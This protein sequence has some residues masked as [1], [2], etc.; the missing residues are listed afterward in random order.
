[1]NHAAVVAR[2]ESRL[3]Q[4]CCLGLPGPTVAPML[5]RELNEVVPFETCFHMWIGT[6]GPIDAYF[7]T[8]E[9]G[10]CFALY[11]DSFFGTR[12][13]EVW[14]TT[15]EAARTEV[16]P[17]HV[18]EV[19]RLSKTAY[20]RHPIYNEIVRPCGADVFVRLMVRDGDAP[21]GS[22]QVARRAHDRD[23][24]ADDLGVLR[25]LEPFI[26]HALRSRKALATVESCDA[27]RAIVVVGADGGIRWR[28]SQA[29]RLLSLAHG[30]AAASA[31]LPAGLLDAVRAL[32]AVADARPDAHAPNWRCD[33]AWG[34]FVAR[35]YWLEPS[36]PADSLIGIEIER[37]V[38]LPLRLYEALRDVALP[39][40][41]AEVGLLLAL[42]RTHEQIAGDLHVSRN[43]VV[44]HRR[45]IYNRLGVD[46]CRRSAR[47]I[48]GIAPALTGQAHRSRL[49]RGLRP[50]SS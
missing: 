36:Q 29:D 35:A 8:P 44:Y 14:S 39:E 38:P 6:D 12:E 4:L 31:T 2:A 32:V 1:M 33:N 47:P 37:R 40:R 45:Q 21:V 11:K 19:L 28:S 18:Y 50:W 10:P 27:D 46:S 17:H 5:F 13:A 3:R 48:A 26:A 22:F 7:N 34:S 15:A 9:A 43:T 49:A 20:E 25:R 23:F 16:G 30:H 41:Q 24:G 42:G